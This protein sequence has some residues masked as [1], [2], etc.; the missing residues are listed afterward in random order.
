MVLSVGEIISELAKLLNQYQKPQDFLDIMRVY[1]RVKPGYLIDFDNQND[2]QQALYIFKRDIAPLVEA[3]GLFMSYKHGGYI[4]YDKHLHKKWEGFTF[5]LKSKQKG[6]FFLGYPLCCEMAW[7]NSHNLFWFSMYDI[8][9]RIVADKDQI[10]SKTFT[11]FLIVRSIVPHFP[12]TVTC[13]PSREWAMRLK[14]VNDR[15][16]P[17]LPASY[18]SQEQESRKQ[19][20]FKNFKSIRMQGVQKIFKKSLPFLMKTRDIFHLDDAFFSNVEAFLAAP[21]QHE[22]LLAEIEAYMKRY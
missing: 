5:L 3:L 19:T 14:R 18:F 21:Q 16:A 2:K 11:E 10:A 6:H 4:T 17:F 15:Y 9:K 7:N 1:E 12:C 13:H 8:L 20:D 22:H